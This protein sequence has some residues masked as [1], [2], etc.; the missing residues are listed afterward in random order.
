VLLLTWPV[1]TLLAAAR[2][3]SQLKRNL[4]GIGARGA[5]KGNHLSR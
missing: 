2:W 4:S 3:D 1:G 5:V